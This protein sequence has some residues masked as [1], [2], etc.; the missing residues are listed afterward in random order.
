MA[1]ES[2]LKTMSSAE[3]TAMPINLK[4]GDLG[5]GGFGEEATAFQLPFL[6][7]APATDCPP[8]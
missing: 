1:K 6:T 2:I 5:H 4:L 3:T 8:A 7:A